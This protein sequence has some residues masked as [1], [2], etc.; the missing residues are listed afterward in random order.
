MLNEN[1]NPRQSQEGSGGRT[2]LSLYPVKS[3]GGLSL[4]NQ[5]RAPWTVS[6]RRGWFGRRTSRLPAARHRSLLVAQGRF[7]RPL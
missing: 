4:G 6:D 2:Y 1:V 3:Q 7:P 5:P